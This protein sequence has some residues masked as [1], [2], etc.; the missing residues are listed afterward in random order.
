[1]ARLR[2]SGDQ[3]GAAAARSD[4]SGD[5]RRLSSRISLGPCRWIRS[6]KCMVMEGM[7]LILV[8]MSTVEN[9]A[10]RKKKDS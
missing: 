7:T 10:K 6:L 2:G 8:M 5:T 1:M 9:L 4:Y 3:A